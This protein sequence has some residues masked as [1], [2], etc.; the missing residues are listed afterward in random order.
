MCL[1]SKGAYDNNVLML[2]EC[3]LLLNTIA[4]YNVI[5]LSTT[6]IIEMQREVIKVIDNIFIL[7]YIQ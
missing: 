7:F 5:T 3:T 4:Q 6:G 1:Q 2:Q